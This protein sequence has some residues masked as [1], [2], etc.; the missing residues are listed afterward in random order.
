MELHAF[1]G[2]VPVCTRLRVLGYP[3]KIAFG[4][5]SANTFSATSA[6]AF[7]AF[8]HGLTPVVFCEGG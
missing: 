3:K 1:T 5:L 2:V 8:I 7:V 4:G 6:E